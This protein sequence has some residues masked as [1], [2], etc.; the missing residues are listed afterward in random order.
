MILVVCSNQQVKKERSITVPNT[1]NALMETLR[2]YSSGVPIMHRILALG[3][4]SRPQCDPG[5]LH[6]RE[7]KE[8]TR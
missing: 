8:G 3:F 2:I 7:V 6:D 1:S 5:A 4:E